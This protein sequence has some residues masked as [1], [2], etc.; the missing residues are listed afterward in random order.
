VTLTALAWLVGGAGVLFL[1][2]EARRR[3]QAASAHIRHCID[4]FEPRSPTGA[5]APE[6]RPDSTVAQGDTS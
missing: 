3:A 2:W 6:T 1:C 4:S 5:Q